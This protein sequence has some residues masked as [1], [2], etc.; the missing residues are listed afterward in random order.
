MLSERFWLNDFYGSGVAG[1]KKNSTFQRNGVDRHSKSNA[2]TLVPFVWYYNL[3]DFKHLCVLKS[4]TE[5]Y[6]GANTF[7]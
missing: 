2:S 4:K 7:S 1:K 3:F 6:N 5:I